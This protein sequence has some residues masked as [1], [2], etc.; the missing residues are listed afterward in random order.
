M[1]Q[2]RE[3]SSMLYALAEEIRSDEGCVTTSADLVEEAAERLDTQTVTIRGHQI[4]LI[5][6]RLASGADRN[7]K[8]IPFINYLQSLKQQ[9]D[10]LLEA[11][12][13]ARSKITD[14]HISAGD[15]ECHYP[16]INDAIENAT[17]TCTKCNTPDLCREYGRACDPYDIPEIS[18]PAIVSY[19]T[20]SLGEAIDAEG[21][22][23]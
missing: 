17:V 14:L 11:L 12:E 21:G 9:R 13:F 8:L 22:A 19:P 3:F 15:G 2:S 16:M 4:A 23:A 10:D 6:C 5:E 7:Q 1:K 18:V 20:G